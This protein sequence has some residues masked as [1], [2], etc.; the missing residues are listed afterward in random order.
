MLQV[1]LGAP[2]AQAR[3]LITCARPPMEEVLTHLTDADGRNIE[4]SVFATPRTFE[5]PL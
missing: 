3:R 4:E 2:F 1:I 5:A